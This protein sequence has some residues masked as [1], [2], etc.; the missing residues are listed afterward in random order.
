MKMQNWIYVG[1]KLLAVYFAVVGAAGFVA[2]LLGLI[3]QAANRAAVQV[4]HN[5]A[6]AVPARYTFY[7]L[8]EP[9]CYLAAAAL[10]ALGTPV[11]FKLLKVSAPAEE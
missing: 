7:S 9:L 5:L 11:V 4:T 6:L 8:L 1:V 10:L 2:A 3:L